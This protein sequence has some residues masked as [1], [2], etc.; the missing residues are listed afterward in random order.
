MVDKGG[1]KITVEHRSSVVRWFQKLVVGSCGFR[2]VEEQPMEELRDLYLCLVKVRA[3][4]RAKVCARD[5]SMFLPRVIVRVRARLLFLVPR[6]RGY[7]C[8]ADEMTVNPT[9][10]VSFVVTLSDV[11]YR[12]A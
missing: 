7:E 9:S 10:H 8:A 2:T 11:L 5:R 4:S 6:Q 12:R 3:M 1:Y